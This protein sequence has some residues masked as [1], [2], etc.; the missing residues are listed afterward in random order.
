MS[1]K[2]FMYTNISGLFAPLSLFSIS[3]SLTHHII[4]GIHKNIRNL[5]K[6]I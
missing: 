1:K 2:S 5:P 4:A 3:L 6:E